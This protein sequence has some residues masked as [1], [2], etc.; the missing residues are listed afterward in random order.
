MSYQSTSLWKGAFDERPDDTHANFRKAL[1][2]QL[3]SMRRRV[4][5]L[6]SSIPADCKDLTVHDV[7]HLDALWESAQQICGDK[8][9]LNPAEAFV[10]GA[11]V[12]IHD[13]GLTTLAYPTGKAGL[14]ATTL[15]ADLAAPLLDVSGDPTEEQGTNCIHPDHEASILFEVLRTLHADCA[16]ELC[17]QA[18]DKAQLGP[19]YLI[20]DSELREAYGEAIGRI[21]SSHHWSAERLP[22]ELSTSVGG[23]PSLPAEWTVNECKLACLIRC[24]DAAQVDRTRAPLMLY[25]ALGPR[26]YSNLHWR[27]QSKLNR[28]IL[29]D[30]A[31]HFNSSSAF[32][33]ADADAWWVAFDL[34]SILDRE[35]RATN[36]IL[37]EIGETT[38]AAQRVAGAESPRA[39]SRYVRPNKWRPIDA[40]IRVSDPLRLA[41][42]LG[43]RNLYGTSAF[44]PFRELIQNSADAIRG[45][46]ALEKLGREFGKICV[47]IDQHPSNEGMCLI[48]V[49]DNGI[50]MSER[51]LCTTLVDFGKSFWNSN[52]ITEEFPGLRSLKVKHIG[53]FGIGFFSVFEVSQE[54]RV[55]SRR[56]DAGY[57]D[58]RML[59][60]RGLISRPL[61][62]EAKGSDLPSGTST[63]VTLTIPKRL[64]QHLSVSADDF[65]VDSPA[66]YT[67]YR[68]IMEMG[69][70]TLKSVIRGLSSFLDIELEFIDRRNGESFLHTPDIYEKSAEEFLLEL[71]AVAKPSVHYDAAASLRPIKSDDGDSF[72]RAALD[73]DALLDSKR[74]SRG[75]I[76]VGGIVS[77]SRGRGLRS[78]GTVDIPYVGVVEGRTERAARD[79]SVSIA[80]KRAVMAWLHD[81]IRDLNMEVLRKSEQMTISAFCLAATGTDSGI[82]FAFNCGEI[83]TV[84]AIADLAQRLQ[85]IMVPVSWRYDAWPEIMGYNVLR[86]DYFEAEL[87]E[88]VVVLAA[89]SD[90]LLEEDQAKLFRKSGGG[91]LDREKVLRSWKEGRAFIELIERVWGRE[92]NI[93][94][95]LRPIFSTQIASLAGD[96]WIIS[97]DRT[98]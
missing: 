62:R 80:P 90:R 12:L 84:T 81:Q 19:Q 35:L 50:G 54:V 20:E 70:P 28:P 42:T 56:Y 72:G 18:W 8:W 86:P 10:F 14:K 63:R 22:A 82:P 15:W 48:H 85:R 52:L 74:P 21:A 60:F 41:K 55:T 61:L 87:A 5:Q 45:R 77:P 83:K 75:F 47:T 4:S 92:C 59:E 91:K 3:E 38:F 26:G 11:A 53:K 57:Q 24:A 7:T 29:K 2:T 32:S 64:T 34:A 93:M 76:S 1:L 68:R 97:F 49:D 67:E 33:D 6:I 89:G 13:A 27:S 94:L 96:R 39:F 25:A 79:F 98:G 46:R 43:G 65:L 37:T 16:T 30:D 88:D 40:S 44:V 51:V 66:G 95:A 78:E 23:S 31:I 36:A 58:T 69:G 17:V 71:P 9:A 73:V